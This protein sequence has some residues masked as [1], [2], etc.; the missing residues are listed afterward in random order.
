M[1]LI[2]NIE[3]AT[4]ICSVALSK[5]GELLSLQ[6]EKEG[7]SHAALLTTLMNRCFLETGL[8]LSDLQAVA[9]SK[10][11]GSY[12]G[13]R[14]GVASAKGLCYALDI[15]LISVNTLQSMAANFM[16]Q[17][18]DTHETLLCPM[19]DAR[20]MEVYM[21][22]F[23]TKL[24]FTR[25][26]T[27]TILEADFFK[28]MLNRQKIAFFGDGMPKLKELI[29][30]QENSRFEPNVLPSANGM[31]KFSETSYNSGVFESVAYFEPFY[32][33]DFF[34]S[35]QPDKSVFRQ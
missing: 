21:A 4:D 30:L 33:K 18:P 5:N 9:V 19:I 8:N 13:L 11:P 25:E 23:D 16:I 20:R 12:T 27:A 34:D 6:E 24:N 35:K 17:F 15:P 22:F 1:A 10:G 14:I 2:L 3:T 28:S 7:R 26:T 31:I 29:G 32:L